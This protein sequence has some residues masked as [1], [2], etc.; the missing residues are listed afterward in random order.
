MNPRFQVDEYTVRLSRCC[1]HATNPQNLEWSVPEGDCPSSSH[2]MD[3][4]L[5]GLRVLK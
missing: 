2:V 3:R 5:E 4:Q 1:L